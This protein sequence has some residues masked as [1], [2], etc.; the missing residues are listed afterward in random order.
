MDENNQMEFPDGQGGKVK[1]L[2]VE[3]DGTYGAGSMAELT[4]I[5][6]TKDGNLKKD[7]YPI[8]YFLI[9]FGAL[10]KLNDV[11]LIQGFEIVKIEPVDAKL[12]E[13]GL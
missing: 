6:K 3:L 1:A 11:G 13:L 12:R 4:I 7:T 2:I 10:F 9:N 5:T 8:P